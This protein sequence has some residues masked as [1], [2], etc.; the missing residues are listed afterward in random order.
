MHKGNIT[1][2]CPRVFRGIVKSLYLYSGPHFLSARVPPSH[3][4]SPHPNNSSSDILHALPMEYCA[5][6][7]APSAHTHPKF[8]TAPTAALRNWGNHWRNG[9]EIT[10]TF[11]GV[12][13]PSNCIR[14]NQKVAQYISINAPE[15]GSQDWKPGRD[16]SGIAPHNLSKLDPQLFTFCRNY[17]I[18]EMF[19]NCE[20]VIYF[21][22]YWREWECSF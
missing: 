3:D 21:S 13:E 14:G 7:Q 20:T 4:I 18:L 22:L 5:F 1:H 15:E 9:A 10:S 8:P 11:P 12:A 16:M 2:D 17:Y 19:F 6:P